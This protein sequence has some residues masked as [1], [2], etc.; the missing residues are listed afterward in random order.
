MPLQLQRMIG[1]MLKT[2]TLALLLLT[3]SSALPAK[4][5]AIIDAG[6]SGSRLYFYSYQHTSK[7]SLPVL[8]LLSSHKVTPGLASFADSSQ[9]IPSYLVKLI[10]DKNLTN[11][12][13]TADFYLLATAGM[14]LIPVN[15]QH[16]ILSE[17]KKYLYTHTNF[18]VKEV[19]TIPGKL[20]GVFDWLAINYWNRSLQPNKTVGVLDLGGAS[21]EIAFATKDQNNKNIYKIIV[22][23]TAYRLYS[24][25]N[26]GLGEDQ[27]RHQFINDP[28]C[29]PLAYPLP[30]T[31]TADGDY[32]KCLM[33]I[34]P[35]ITDIHHVMIRLPPIPKSKSFIAV[36]GY[37]YTTK[38]LAIKSVPSIASFNQ[39]AA[40][41]CRTNWLSLLET[42]DRDKY[43][44][45][46]CFN[47]AL[48]SSLLTKGYGFNAHWQIMAHKL[49]NGHDPDWTAG[50]A[51]YYG[52]HPAVNN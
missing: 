23:N 6:S 27:A 35:L 37:F 3:S 39:A 48:I 20:E 21:A 34:R 4:V 12:E 45:M 9:T 17:V 7:S 49:I 14:R 42:H 44:S 52:E 47:A 31:S 11:S 38:A 19:A 32:A 2:I 24:Q 25:S 50:A 10:N 18:Q 1:I 33:D 15:Q 40:Q 13:K 28:H 41:L 51:I 43:L 16:L 26:L 5:I 29:F 36:S 22:G 8:Q 30:N 46:H